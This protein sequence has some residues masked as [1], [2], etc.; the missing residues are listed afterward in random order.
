MRIGITVW[1]LIVLT[2]CQSTFKVDCAR[3]GYKENTPEFRECVADRRMEESVRM[4]KRAA[5]EDM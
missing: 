3:E 4:K 2:A 5:G 1:G